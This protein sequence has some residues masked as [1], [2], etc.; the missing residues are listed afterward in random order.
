MPGEEI[1][2][3]QAASTEQDDGQG[4]NVDDILVQATI[5]E[6]R[7][8]LV[9]TN[10]S[11]AT[12][13]NLGT[14]QEIINILRQSNLDDA[15][16][17][18]AL[19]QLRVEE[20][21]EACTQKKINQNKQ[22]LIHYFFPLAMFLATI[23][24]GATSQ[25]LDPSEGLAQLLVPSAAGNVVFSLV[26]FLASKLHAYLNKQ[27]LSDLDQDSLWKTVATEVTNYL[28][29]TFTFALFPFLAE[30]SQAV[31]KT[32][33]HAVSEGELSEEVVTYLAYFIT[34]VI[35]AILFK[36]EGLTTD[37]RNVFQIFFGLTASQVTEHLMR[38]K[39][40]FLTLA[41]KATAAGLV[42]L[43][44][45]A[46]DSENKITE[47]AIKIA[48]DCVVKAKDCAVGGVQS[49]CNGVYSVGSS[50]GSGVRNVYQRFFGTDVLTSG[51]Q[52]SGYQSIP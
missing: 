45:G 9:R 47:A 27:E 28:K 35:L 43:L 41:S 2:T 39:D 32:S 19:V 13:D 33:V 51:N 18:K 48:G 5:S 6:I 17:A 25:L 8:F 46:I 3:E 40:F 49:V 37:W 38:S 36:G 50:I 34:S 29:G 21:Q 22:D 15:K 24:S 4:V 11:S 42:S 31:M 30:A 26:F 16:I 44:I 1:A 52:Q 7:N 20:K 12:Q 14:A 23:A 10:A